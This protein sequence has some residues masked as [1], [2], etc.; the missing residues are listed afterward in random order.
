MKIEIKDENYAA[1]LVNLTNET[2][3]EK[4]DKLS[5]YNANGYTVLAEKNIS[6]NSLYIYFPAECTINKEFLAKNNL[7]NKSELNVDPYKKGFIDKS[8]RVKTLSLKGSTSDGLALNIKTLRTILT[9]EQYDYITKQKIGTKFTDIDNIF[10]CKKYIIQSTVQNHYVPKTFWEKIKFKFSNKKPNVLKKEIPEGFNFHVDTNHLNNNMHL[11]NLDDEIYIT[12]KLH[13]TSA[14]FSN[15]EI[16]SNFKKFLKKIGIPYKQ[17]YKVIYSSRKVI[18]NLKPVT[19]G[20]YKEDPWSIIGKQI[21][22]VIPKGYSIYG[23]IVGYLPSGKHIQKGYHYNAKDLELYIYRITQQNK[24]GKII[25]LSTSEIISFCRN[26]KLNHVH[27][28]TTGK[29]IDLLIRFNL[30]KD[31]N[32]WR[33]LLLE[34]LKN[35]KEADMEETCPLNNHEVPTEGL[36]LRIENSERFR[37]YKLKCLKFKERETKELDSGEIDI[38]TEN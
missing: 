23:E 24:F 4:L 11:L 12:R 18:K 26:N 31:S 30:D 9:W 32:N 16:T 38:E 35:W 1:I 33:D 6:P 7:F 17:Q 5:F 15:L 3:P 14:I 13:G 36:V 29:V 28:I 37:A 10:I 21:E 22:N 8:G 27:I 34:K 25:E 20:F 19:G 2:K